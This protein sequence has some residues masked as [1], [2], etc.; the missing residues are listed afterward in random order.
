MTEDLLER[1]T[2]TENKTKKP[3]LYAVLLVNDDAVS[4]EVV[5]VLLMRHFGKSQDEAIQIMMKAHVDQLSLVDVY[6]KEI[7]ETKSED[8]MKDGQNFGF[9]VRF[10]LE[11]QDLENDDTPAFRGP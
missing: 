10:E 6:P 5:A 1:K 7:A 3:P 4:G 8:A 2:D 11:P 9:S